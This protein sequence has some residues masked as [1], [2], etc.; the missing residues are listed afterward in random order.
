MYREKHSEHIGI[1]WIF[2]AERAENW[3]FSQQVFFASLISYVRKY[4]VKLCRFLLISLN[5]LGIFRSFQA[6]LAVKLRHISNEIR[7]GDDVVDGFYAN[8]NVE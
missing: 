4:N 1:R 3:I 7:E 8:D 6:F 5:E 2:L